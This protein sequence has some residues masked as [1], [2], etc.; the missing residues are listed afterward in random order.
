MP[1]VRSA[2][3]IR[4]EFIDYFAEK[5]G[6]IYVPSSSV[7]PHDDP[8]LLFC[9]AGMN[10]FKDV[11]LGTG[12][13]PYSRAVN[14]QKC[15]RAGGKHNDL[16]D[17]GKD[18][19]HHTFFEMLGNW[20][21]GDYFKEEAIRW[22]WELLTE[23]WG[24]DKNRLHAT[25][26]A[27]DEADGTPADTEAE[28]IWKDVTDID[29]SHV[30]R[31]DKKDNFWE[32]GE[33]GPCGPCSEIHYDFTPNCSGAKLV[34][35]DDERVIEIW[36]LVFI[37]HNRGEDGSL[38]PLPAKHVDTGMGF[39]RVVRVIQNKASNY[40]IDLWMPLFLAI[41]QRS[42]V[43]A[44][45]GHLNDP[46]DV[47]YRV[48]ADHARCLTVA[49]S[50]GAEPGNEGRGYVLRRILRRG[51]RHARQTLGV[52]GPFL[53]QLVYPVIDSMGEAYPELMKNP[54]RVI[55]I[56]RDEEESFG[57]TL[58]RGLDLFK[59]AADR[60]R[61]ST[62][63]P[64]LIAADDA[65]KLHDTYGFPIDLTEVMA[66]ERG[67]T[68]D[69][70]GYEQLMD[71]ARQR[72]RAG[73]T[74][75]GSGKGGASIVLDGGQLARLKHMGIEETKDVDKFHGHVMSSRI[76][77][78]WNGRD[79]DE[80]LSASIGRGD[81]TIG[82]ITNRT[83][84]YAE[85]GG[86]VCDV[87]RLH[88]VHD[89]GEFHVLDTQVFGGYVVHIGQMVKGTF[90]VGD[91]VKL[92]IDH[93][94]RLPIMRNHT[95]T[96]LL[97]HA[98]RAVLGDHV[99]QKGSS[100]AP[101]R[102]RF[103]F[104]HRAAVTIEELGQ[105]NAMVAERIDASLQVYAEDV[106]LDEAKSIHGLRAVFGERYP[107]PVRVV[108]IG[109]P[110]EAL[111]HQSD[112]PKWSDYSIE[113]C[114]G[115]HVPST[116]TVVALTITHEETI[117]KGVRRITALTGPEAV[118]A[119]A[120]AENMEQ[121][122]ENLTEVSDDRLPLELAELIEQFDEV[123]MPWADQSRLRA[124]IQGLQERV[125]TIR[126]AGER[127]QRA[128]IV[129]QARDIAEQAEGFVIVADIAQ[130]TADTLR[131]AMDV[132]R[133]KHPE[134]AVLLL[135]GQPETNKVAM[136]ARVPK[137]LIERGLKAGDWVREVAAVCGGRGGGRPDM[138]QAGGQDVGCIH[139]AMV[140]AHEVA[141]STIS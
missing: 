9:N 85:M 3:Q 77:A 116:D 109:Q 64:G 56:I 37:Q 81:D 18:N 11:F 79:F 43:R 75:G 57:R 100:V 23:V 12:N 129:D 123:T 105:I 115:T 4:R 41:E 31:W 101:D 59:Q 112:N 21:F 63:E 52:S 84:F 113:L 106:P 134:A 95:G 25:V 39:E 133:E 28:Q 127:D 132:I 16:E 54:D 124:R 110:V 22:A 40:D 120:I 94:Q 7:V 10:Q 122:I 125:K 8:T 6:H 36:N 90:S 2:S 55:E 99:E 44:Y 96:H 49:L 92:E 83:N 34:N 88:S 61:R 107:D 15:I 74:K 131:S 46:V 65:F 19:Y 51:I 69:L 114:G 42:G 141:E 103:D 117:A 121:Q 73:Q 140:R 138:A 5:H 76:T 108:S 118:E 111:R 13:R 20:S 71:E 136:M 91:R 58:D 66:E 24:L 97:N 1:S 67:M 70:E 102:L 86:Q 14:T 17:V 137:S 50:D 30:S 89:S 32:M 62:D 53:S 27:G 47:A 68:V 78:I 98:L 45:G 130:A 119:V 33:T 87:G 80:H 128:G 48:I 93:H 38:S 60:A 29:P 126:K 104:S 135:S 26:F 72:A 35:A 139:D 82:V